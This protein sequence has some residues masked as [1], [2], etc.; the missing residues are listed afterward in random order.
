[1]PELSFSHF[2][3]YVFDLPRMEAFYTRLL[4]F[5]V[6]DR[7]VARGRDLV[8]LSRDPREHHQ[9]VLVAG[10]AAGETTVNQISF[11]LPSLEALQALARTVRAEPGVSGVM[12]TNHGN[13]WSLYFRD[14]EGNRIELFVD[15]PWYVS[16]PRVEPLDLDRPAEEI[17]AATLAACRDDPSFRPVEEWRAAFAE[18]LAAPKPI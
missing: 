18:R 11:R 7:G 2:G 6:T 14:P 8:F 5:E 3:F 16:Q 1:M 13:S 15:A 17:V 9:I 4:G 10:R 12:G